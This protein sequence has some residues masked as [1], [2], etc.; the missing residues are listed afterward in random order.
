MH[1][2]VC[3]K[4]VPDTT[5]VSID[6]VTNT[7]VRE[8]VPFITNPYDTN[9]V[10]EAI[11]F[12]DKYGAYVTAV[13]MGPPNAESVLRKAISIGADEGILLSDR[14]FGGADTLATSTVLGLAIKKIDEKR[15][16]DIV[17][18]GKQTIDGDTAQVGP[19]IARR[20][21]ITQLTLVDE[22]ISVN[23]DKKLI[24]VRRKLET[25]HEVVEAQL[26][27][28]M[29][30]EREINDP[31]Y[32]TVPG[33]LDADDIQIQV[34]N[35]AFLKLDPNSIGLLGS[36]TQVRRIFAPE[37]EAGEVMN[38]EGDQMT[39]A[40]DTMFDKLKEWDFITTS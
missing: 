17:L 22:V 29:T 36:P 2:V 25:Y 11:R 14:A 5:Q 15:P 1:I 24:K 33:R 13:S 40:T 34:W 20:M 12:K 37:R 3:V 8:G 10:E 27:V 18:C 23:Q 32:P 19:G 31:R 28:M 26:P 4:M 35:N 38:G 7:L 6:P 16:V 39:V 9:A 30:V 21:D